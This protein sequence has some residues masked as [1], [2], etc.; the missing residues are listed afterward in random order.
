[1]SL[2]I[3]G[4]LRRRGAEKALKP[5]NPDTAMPM[6]VSPQANRLGRLSQLLDRYVHA[7][8]DEPW[9]ADPA[10]R[11]ALA[12]R[13][14][15]NVEIV[16]RSEERMQAM[17][18]PSKPADGEQLNGN[19]EHDERVLDALERRLAQRLAAGGKNGGSEEPQ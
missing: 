17:M 11:A 15:R 14:I 19:R 10:K 16:L 8:E 18:A 5:Q 4:E 1:M 13:G 12:D 6:S 9:P 2:V 3:V 7:L